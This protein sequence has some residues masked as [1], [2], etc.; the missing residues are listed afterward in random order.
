MIG[1]AGSGQA[2]SKRRNSHEKSDKEDKWSEIYEQSLLESDLHRKISEG[3]REDGSVKV[4]EI[5]D[6]SDI[7]YDQTTTEIGE[8]SNSEEDSGFS[9][10]DM[11]SGEDAEMNVLTLNAP[12]ENTISVF[13]QIYLKDTNLSVGSAKYIDD[14]ISA[15]WDGEHYEV[16]GEPSVAAANP[17]NASFHSDSYQENG[18]SAHANLKSN[19][20][21]GGLPK[22]DRNGLM[23]ELYSQLEYIGDDITPIFGHY[24]HTESLDGRGAI[25][26]ITVSKG[27]IELELSGF[28]SKVL[29]EKGEFSDPSEDL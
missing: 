27:S 24:S 23:I 12:P 29:W 1:A 5:L 17:H 26:S 14:V 11:Y 18:L 20:L 4:K 7:A 3:F 6:E 2:K 9:T 21:L 13:V 15:T 19:N 16:V 25:E 10:Q 28:D 8:N 22:G